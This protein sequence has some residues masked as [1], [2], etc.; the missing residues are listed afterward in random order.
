[1]RDYSKEEVI[2]AIKKSIRHWEKDVIFKYAVGDRVVGC[3]GSYMWKSDRS[4]LRIYTGDCNLCLFFYNQYFCLNCPYYKTF[5][6][7]C[8]SPDKGGSINKPVTFGHWFR[9]N[10]KPSRRT[11]ERMRNA[12]IRVL[13]FTE[14]NRESK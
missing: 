4:P 13:K 8:F 14:N 11:A 1:M 3:P 6:H 5:G 2:E 9:F 10:T 7:F 12:L